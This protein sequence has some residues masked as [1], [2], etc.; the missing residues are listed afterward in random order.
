MNIAVQPLSF[1]SRARANPYFRLVT[2]FVATLAMGILSTFPTAM[3]VRLMRLWKTDLPL[4][5]KLTPGG[6]LD[7]LT[8]VI[9]IIMATV[10]LAAVAWGYTKLGTSINPEV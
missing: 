5:A 7:P 1:W 2:L 9:C 6:A 3:A 10:S 8:G 4:S